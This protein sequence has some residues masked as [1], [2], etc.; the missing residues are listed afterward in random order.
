MQT[1]PSNLSYL[2]LRRSVG[3]IGIGL[4]VALI[5]AGLFSGNIETTMSGF[6]HTGMQDIFVASNCIVGVF[7]LAYGG[8]D[9]ADDEWFSDRALAV[10]TGFGAIVLA[11]IPTASEGATASAE[12]FFGNIHLIAAACF[13]LGLGVF[14]FAKF[15][16]TSGPYKRTYQVLGLVIFA[17]IAAIGFGKLFLPDPAKD[18]IW[19]DW[20]FWLEVVAVWAFGISW[21]IKGKTMEGMKNLRTKVINR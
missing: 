4:P 2:I 5:V 6:Y 10:F 16:R 3:G 9:K 19:Q 18:S 13:F 17:A 7:L 11:L 20:V 21:L 15:S 14:S 8:Y 1:E 12:I